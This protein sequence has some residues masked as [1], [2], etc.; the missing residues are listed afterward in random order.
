MTV[1]AVN[2]YRWKASLTLPAT[3]A[4]CYRVLLDSTDLLGGAAALQFQTNVQ[5]GATEAFK[6]AVFG[7]W[8]QVD[9]EREQP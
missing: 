8:G 1:G 3:G 5:P 7:D 4:Y 6:F 9:C 2:E